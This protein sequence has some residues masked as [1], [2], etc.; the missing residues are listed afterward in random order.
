MSAPRRPLSICQVSA[1]Y[2]PYPSGVSELVHHL[3]DELRARGHHVQILTT[4]F[5][6]D[7]PKNRDVT[8]IGRAILLP[9]N[10]SF[11]TVPFDLDMSGKVKRFLRN[12]TFDVVHVNGFFPPDIAYY[13]LHHSR[14]VNVASFLTVG[15][16]NYGP[17]AWLWNLMSG[18]LNRRMHGR[19]ALTQGALKYIQPFFPGEFRIIPPGVDTTRFRPLPPSPRPPASVPGPLT[20]SI[21]FVGR[22]DKRKGL[23]VLLRAMP[24]VASRF[25]EVRLTVVGKGPMETESRRLAHKLGLGNRVEFKGYAA[26]NDLPAFYAS[27][28]VYCSPALGGE[29]F[30]IVLLEAMACGTPVVASDITGYNEVITHGKTGLLCPPNDPAALARTLVEMLSRPDLREKLRA[31]GLKKAGELSWPRIAEQVEDYYQELLDRRKAG[32][33]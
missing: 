24:E 8:R 29:A 1:A 17:G 5:G 7:G 32:S 23:D 4:S 30:G 6:G 22:L 31:A 3:S 16:R 11:A 21:L 20:P 27:A 15:F 19:I 26:N 2:Y 13:A 12:D 9:M 10:K 14:S 28:D 18:G 25:P 33:R